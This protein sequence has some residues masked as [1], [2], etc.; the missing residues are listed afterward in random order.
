MS[1]QTTEL[2][3]DTIAKFTLRDAIAVGVGVA[4]LAGVYWKTQMDLGEMRSEIR[5]HQS[6]IDRQDKAGEKLSDSIDS[7]R[8]A[9]SNLTNVVGKLETKLATMDKHS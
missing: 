3:P 1:H 8:A 6:S 4:S 2:G 7:L 9:I 5:S